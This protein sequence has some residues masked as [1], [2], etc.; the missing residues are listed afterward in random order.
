[1]EVQQDERY[2][3]PLEEILPFSIYDIALSSASGKETDI[4]S[5]RKGK[6]TLLFNVAAGCGNIPQH[7]ILEE[8]NQIYKD[9][10]DFNILAV[11][12]DDFACHGYPEFQNGIQAYIDKNALDCTVGE[13]SEDYAQE[14]F[15][16]T[17]EFSELTNGRHDKHTYDPSFV[18]GLKKEQEQHTLWSY[19][20]GA[21]NATM[22]KN[23]IPANEELVTWSS[24]KEKQ[25]PIGTV[26]FSPLTG[27]FTK[28]LIDKTGT[29]IKRYQNGFLLG[30]RGIDGSTF[31]WKLEKYQADGRRDHNPD[32]A[33][34]TRWD[35]NPSQRNEAGKHWP[36]ILQR[37]GADISISLML[38]D[39]NAYLKD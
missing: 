13:A 22:C 21:Y 34:I 33:P 30:E 39:I 26:T 9:D 19:L 18:P 36:D 7:N 23:G 1:M 8:I 27:N 4:L 31:P 38:R 11:V 20:T 15:N 32:L 29:R 5:S 25:V 2:M 17:Y 12:V 6:V 16:V 35:Q 14:H 10:D 24:A 37:A 28:F 3:S